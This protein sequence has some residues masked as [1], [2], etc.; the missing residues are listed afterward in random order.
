MLNSAGLGGIA[1][2]S[3]RNAGRQGFYNQRSQEIGNS[4]ESVIVLQNKAPESSIAA[5]ASRNTGR[6]LQMI[7][8]LRLLTACCVI[9]SFRATFSSE[10]LFQNSCRI[11]H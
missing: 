9:F 3:F 4:I 5:W 1:K 8:L 6:S 10:T 7:F 11:S 2:F